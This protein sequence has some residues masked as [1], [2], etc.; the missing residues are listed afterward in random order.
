M[1]FN[2]NVK[3][4]AVPDKHQREAKDLIIY[5]QNCNSDLFFSQTWQ[6]IFSVSKQREGPVGRDRVL[7]LNAVVLCRCGPV[8]QG[9]E[10]SDGNV[11]DSSLQRSYKSFKFEMLPKVNCC[12][13]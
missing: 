2:W 6:D 12:K 11:V 10:S 4:A 8:G 13:N 5:T 7:H 1:N 3:L 9:V